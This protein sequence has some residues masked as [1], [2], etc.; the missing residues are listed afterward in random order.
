MREGGCDMGENPKLPE[1]KQI[2]QEWL[3]SL[4]SD[5]TKRLYRDVILTVCRV[6]KTELSG[7]TPKQWVYFVNRY[8]PK[9]ITQKQISVSTSRIY[10]YAVCSYLTYYRSKYPDFP[11]LEQE[12]FLS[13]AAAVLPDTNRLPTAE[14]I[15]ALL[16]Y[17]GQIDLQLQLILILAY[18]CAL[19]LGEI[20]ELKISDIRETEAGIYYLAIRGER[21]RNIEIRDDV[22]QKIEIYLTTGGYPVEEYLF[23]YP[24][25]SDPCSAR[26]LQKRIKD[27]QEPLK[28]KQILPKTYSLSAIRT[29]AIHRILASDH[30][31]CVDTAKYVGVRADYVSRIQSVSRPDLCELPGDR[32]RLKLEDLLL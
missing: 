1:T 23:C 22:Y 12:S 11:D 27:L 18:E 25:K 29:A 13:P 6:S 30:A 9:Q 16:Q 24:K 28:E 31:D 14:H 15:S 3:S 8:I 21:E 10:Y 4:G 19:S 17:A 20:R 32:K 26:Y 5:E 7:L 2:F